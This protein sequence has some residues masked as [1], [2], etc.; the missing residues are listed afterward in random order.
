MAADS[1]L[2]E[3]LGSQEEPEGTGPAAALAAYQ[4]AH[5]RLLSLFQLKARKQD[6]PRKTPDESNRAFGP[7]C[8]T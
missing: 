6:W 4:S 8:L 1:L 7:R 5:G 3:V 2:A